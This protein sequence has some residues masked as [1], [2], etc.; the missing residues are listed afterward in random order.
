MKGLSQQRDDAIKTNH[1]QECNYKTIAWL[2]E[3]RE[4]WKYSKQI[5][6]THT[7]THMYSGRQKTLEVQCNITLTVR[8]VI[9]QTRS[10]VTHCIKVMQPHLRCCRLSPRD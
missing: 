2:S 10:R 5:H 1:V 3:T 6:S 8:N 9:Q 7:H 4:Y